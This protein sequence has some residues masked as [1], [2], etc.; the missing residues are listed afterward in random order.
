MA[1]RRSSPRQKAFLKGVIC[2]NKRASTIEC[3][4]RDL[5]DGGAR[6][7]VSSA[8]AVPEFFELFVPTRNQYIDARQRWRRNDDLGV[9][10]VQNEASA[11]TSGVV[12]P[13]DI[14]GRVQRLEEE[15]ESLRRSL[16]KLRMDLQRTISNR[17]FSE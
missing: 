9:E 16:G 17:E 8:V 1:E 10:F 15:V 3:T 6:L 14:F 2:Y 11:Q 4:I 12:A 7:A 13:G 5:S